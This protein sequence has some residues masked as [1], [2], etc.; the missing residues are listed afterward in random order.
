MP[1]EEK[2]VDVASAVI[3]KLVVWVSEICSQVNTFYIANHNLIASVRFYKL[4]VEF[5]VRT[6]QQ[7]QYIYSGTVRAP[8]AIYE[9]RLRLKARII[10]DA[11]NL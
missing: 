5:A 8:Q 11:V 4:K 3:R 2:M 7:H 9:L 1:C 6:K 10:H